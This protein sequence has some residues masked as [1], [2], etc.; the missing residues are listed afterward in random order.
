MNAARWLDARFHTFG[1]AHE[2]VYTLHNGN[3]RGY[4]DADPRSMEGEVLLDPTPR[5][6]VMIVDDDVV[7]SDLLGTLWGPVSGSAI[8][9]VGVAQT[10]ADAL[11]LIGSIRPD[12][13]LMEHHLPDMTGAAVASAV[14]TE[15]PDI[16]VVMLTRDDSDEVLLDGVEAGAIGV[17]LKRSGL[18]TLV[19]A[20]DRAARGEPLMPPAVMASIAAALRDRRRR[21]AGTDLADRLT[22]REIEVLCL[23]AEGCDDQTIATRLALGQASIRTQVE[24]LLTKLDAHSRLQ[25]VVRAK[26]LR[27]VH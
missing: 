20:V 2:Y 10:G 3:P 11:A 6:G 7:L 26:Q 17:L 9:L 24:A 12:V 1:V 8:E 23:V 13:L 16:R 4:A 21:D 5:T 22:A 15:F 25:A 19:E 14:T 18:P 27:V